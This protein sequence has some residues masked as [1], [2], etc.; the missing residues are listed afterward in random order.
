MLTRILPRNEHPIERA[1]RVVLGLTLLSL[2]F[3][4][5]KV[6]W[7]FFGAVPLLTGLLGS[8]PLYT[9]FGVS[10]CKAIARPKT[11]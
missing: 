10:T 9:L 5:P 2:A 1:L 3:F 8:C 7:G 4:G 6:W 11:T